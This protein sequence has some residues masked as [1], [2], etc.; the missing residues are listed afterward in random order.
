MVLWNRFFK[1][2]VDENGRK[3]ALANFLSYFIEI[4]LLRIEVKCSNSCFLSAKVVKRAK[5]ELAASNNTTHTPH[6]V[7]K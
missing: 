5:K 3:N 6:I 7:R 2:C 4:K 1:L